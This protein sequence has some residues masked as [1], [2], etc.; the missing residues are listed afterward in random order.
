MHIVSYEMLITFC[1]FR[2]LV[3][4]NRGLNIAQN[5]SLNCF[6][7]GMWVESNLEKLLKHLS[8]K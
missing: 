5:L 6:T 7:H 1:L 4:L 8:S 3:T 2:G